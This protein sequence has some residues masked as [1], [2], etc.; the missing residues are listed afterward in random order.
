LW[1]SWFE[2][3]VTSFRYYD[4][5]RSAAKKQQ[6]T[7]ESQGKALKSAEKKTKQTLKEVQTM[8]SINKARKVFW[9]E[10]FFWFIS[11][12]N[13]LGRCAFVLLDL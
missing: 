1:E 6:K 9:F 8:T 5:K 4:Q 7:L 3:L 12:E 2:G 11:S 13:Y 10:K